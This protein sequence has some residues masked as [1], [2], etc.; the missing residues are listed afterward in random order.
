MSYEE[1]YARRSELVG[2]AVDVVAKSFFL[3]SCPPQQQGGATRCVLTLYAAD[4][5]RSSLAYGQRG[6]A[7]VVQEDG[8][9]VSC[10]S[11]KAREGACP[12]WENAKRYR[13]IAE[14]RKQVL[15]GRE[16]EQVALDVSSKS[17]A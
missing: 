4:P 2:E 9:T 12:G 15:G 16:T 14:V 8:R 11:S 13:L 10:A 3:V 7:M 6:E 17:S 5:D 1:V